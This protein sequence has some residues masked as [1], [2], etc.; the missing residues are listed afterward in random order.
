MSVLDGGGND[1]FFAGEK[2]TDFCDNLID[3]AESQKYL[4]IR[5]HPSFGSFL[6]DSAPLVFL[7][8]SPST[9]SYVMFLHLRPHPIRNFQSRET[10]ILR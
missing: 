4:E 2:L 8:V 1:A 7:H 5:D 10:T 9:S 3:A 6:E